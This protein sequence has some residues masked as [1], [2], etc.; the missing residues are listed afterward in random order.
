MTPFDVKP[1]DRSVA[2]LSGGSSGIG[3]AAARRMMTNGLR[4]VMLNGRSAERGS[5]VAE[6]LMG[7]FPGADVRFVAADAATPDGAERMVAETVG[8]FSGLDI[9][10]TSA[11]GDHMPSLLHAT[12]IA[13]IPDVVDGLLL[14]AMLPVRAALPVMSEAGAGAIV[15]VASDAAKVATPGET[16]VGAAMAGIVMFSR[17][18]AIEAKRNGVRV[19]CVTPSIVRGTPLYDRLMEDGFAG[20]LFVK[21][22]TMAHLGVADADD[23]AEAVAF[24]ASPA[25]AR[26]TGQALSVNGGISAA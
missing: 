25:A 5:R 18:T 26:I 11:G 7:E 14:S 24:L 17:A 22:E 21:A 4:R 3:L 16:V 19:N 9:L 2:L 1:M 12:P 13:A 15:T 8:A 10:V 20:K 6:A 23:V